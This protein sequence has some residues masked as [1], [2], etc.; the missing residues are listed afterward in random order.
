MGFAG[1]GYTPV[2]GR[3]MTDFGA[4]AVVATVSD[5]GRASFLQQAGAVDFA[6]ALAVADAVLYEGYLL[7]P[8]RPSSVKNRVRWQFGVLA[9][10]A[11]IDARTLPDNDGVAGSSESWW[12][13]TECLVEAGGGVTVEVV[14]RFL[15]PEPPSAERATRGPEGEIATPDGAIPREV[16]LAFRL[17]EATEEGITVAFE[18]PAVGVTS[19]S[20]A[21]GRL[22]VNAE[23]IPA[24]FPLHKLSVRVENTTAA[25]PEL[26][27]P[28]A[29]RRS[30]V[31]THLL[32][33]LQ[34]GA[35]LS[36]LDPPEWARRLTA[37]ACGNVR[38][39]PVLAG[40]PGS[41]R[42]LLSS[43]IILYD[44]PQVAPESPG[45]LFDATEIDEILTLRALT[46]TEQEKAEARGTDWRAAEIVDR[47][48][49]MPDEILARL[50][51]AIR[52]LRRLP[53]PSTPGQEGDGEAGSD[54]P[55]TEPDAVAIGGVSV[56]AGS[57]VRLHPRGR[58]TD[59]QD[60]FLDGRIGTVTGV[61]TDVDGS[62]FLTVTVDDDPRASLAAGP[63]RV[64]HFSPDEVHPLGSAEEWTS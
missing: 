38:T 33:G 31:S 42:L 10:P 35:F 55:G 6:P 56:G 52:S 24:R 64:R 57:R 41:D 49:T 58:G 17:A 28:E 19:V 60:M 15:Q 37:G 43:P 4:G 9:P 59:A 30:F 36:L 1:P 62:R 63:G 26:P 50:H 21:R 54:T 53:V 39:F 3:A 18:V 8:Y 13:R 29:L 23:Q 20:A 7:Y 12:N 34:E 22:R 44:H 27:R 48:D 32:L 47:V 40:P 5:S 25:A 46:L 11:W 2:L 16:R 45:D 61:L 14:L 51:G